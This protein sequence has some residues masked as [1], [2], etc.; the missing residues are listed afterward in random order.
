[1]DTRTFEIQMLIDTDDAVT[2]SRIGSEAA[3]RALVAAEVGP[4]Q[5]SPTIYVH[6]DL[7]SPE[8]VRVNAEL[9]DA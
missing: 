5:N 1:L 4:P 2:A 3:H 9:V 7:I 8:A 6:K